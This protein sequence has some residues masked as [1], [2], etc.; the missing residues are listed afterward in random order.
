LSRRR[1]R[2][3]CDGG[4]GC[5]AYAGFDLV[6]EEDPAAAELVAREDAAAGVVEGR[7]ERH[8]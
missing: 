5:V 1:F 7:G 8:V 4:A 3:L 2:V 6:A